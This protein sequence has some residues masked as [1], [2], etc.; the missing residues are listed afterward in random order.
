MGAPPHLRH[1]GLQ[2]FLASES[3]FHGAKSDFN[4]LA[5]M[6]CNAGPVSPNPEN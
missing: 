1:Q 3:A 6:I 5:K 4:E 2:Q